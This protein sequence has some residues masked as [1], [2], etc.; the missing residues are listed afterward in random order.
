[1]LL[2]E[3]G[4]TESDLSAASR[5]RLFAEITRLQTATGGTEKRW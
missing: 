3:N 4:L 2:N 1:M 5:R